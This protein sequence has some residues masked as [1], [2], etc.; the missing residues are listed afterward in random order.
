MSSVHAYEAAVKEFERRRA[1]VTNAAEGFLKGSIPLEELRTESAAAQAA[2]K[3]RDEALRRWR[4]PTSYEAAQHDVA[5]LTEEQRARLQRA[6][7]FIDE[8]LDAAMVAE[9]LDPLDTGD[10]EQ[11][12]SRTSTRALRRAL[13]ALEADVCLMRW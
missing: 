3:A 12:L 8:Q 13:S 9:G 11:A 5:R 7:A 4:E 6:R 10:L 2:E 1:R